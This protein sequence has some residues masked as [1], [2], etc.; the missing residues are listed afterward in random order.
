M[1]SQTRARPLREETMTKAKAI[2]AFCRECMSSGREVTICT[3]FACPLWEHRLGCGLRSRA[4]AERIRAAFKAGGC[5]IEEVRRL[6]Y[7]EAEFL[8]RGRKPVPQAGGPEIARPTTRPIKKN[9]LL[10]KALKG[11]GSQLALAGV[12]GDGGAVS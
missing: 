3:G 11:P 8:R 2:A 4:Y 1:R 9:A 6:G 10:R 12:A 5:H 7:G